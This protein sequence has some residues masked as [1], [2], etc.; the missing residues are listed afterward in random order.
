MCVGRG[1]R[2]PGGGRGVKS[3]DGGERVCVQW[4]L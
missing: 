2:G 1:A 4:L 3:A